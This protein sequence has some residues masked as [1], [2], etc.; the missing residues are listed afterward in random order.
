[1]SYGLMIAADFFSSTQLAEIAKQAEQCGFDNLWVPEMFGRDPFITCATLLNATSSIQVGTAITNI[2]ARDERAIKA[3][4]YSLAEASGNRFE[5]GIGVSNKVG[6]DQRGLP[7]IAPVKK[8]N[9]FLDRYEATD[10]MFQHNGDVPI[11]LAAHGPKLMNV[12]A[13]RLNGAYVY[14]MPA[15][16]SRQSKER[17]GD[18]KKLHLMQPTVFETDAEK[19]REHARRAV[20]IYMPLENYHRAWREAGFAD[21]DFADGGS[22]YFIDTLIAWGD[23]QKILE[24]YQL[25]RDNGIDQIILSPTNLDIKAATTWPQ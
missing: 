20:S 13:K 15:E 9:A 17:I 8:L 10:L 1:M 22:D 4:A 14:M 12:A 2:Y 3:A 25:H 24:R 19:A 7:W 6:N 23:Q 18:G 16:Y 21:S 5:L 11:Y